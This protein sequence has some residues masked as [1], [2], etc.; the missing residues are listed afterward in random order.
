MEEENAEEIERGITIVYSKLN[1]YINV[2]CDIL[3]FMN[4]LE[5]KE[6]GSRN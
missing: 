5:L 3:L 4:A 6:M 1:W 2:K